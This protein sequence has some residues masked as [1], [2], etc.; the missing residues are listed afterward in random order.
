M[1]T[2]KR[3]KLKSERF[4]AIEELVEKFEE[5][6]RNKKT[7]I[8]PEVHDYPLRDGEVIHSLKGAMKAVKGHTNWLGSFIENLVFIERAAVRMKIPLDELVDFLLE[9]AKKNEE[10]HRQANED[11]F[12]ER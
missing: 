11:E 7:H 6:I 10:E 2:E 4:T 8:G 1:K 3:P 5:K 9:E 12:C